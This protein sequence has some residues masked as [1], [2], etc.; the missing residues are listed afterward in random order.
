LFFIYHLSVITG[1][2]KSRSKKNRD[3]DEPCAH[4]SWNIDEKSNGFSPIMVANGMIPLSVG[5]CS[6]DEHDGNKAKKGSV[7][8]EQRGGASA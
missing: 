1:A 5:Q 4:D 2:E 8:S 3:C 6:T 7:K